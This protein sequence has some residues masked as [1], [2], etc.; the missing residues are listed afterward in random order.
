[1]KVV[2]FDYFKKRGHI[3]IEH[4]I[5]LATKTR[6]E[7]TIALKSHQEGRLNFLTNLSEV[8]LLEEFHL[9]CHVAR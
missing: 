6:N 9:S 7:I 5:M 4:V 8:K 2:T 1:M 3:S